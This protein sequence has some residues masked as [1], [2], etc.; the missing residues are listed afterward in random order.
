MT[1]A[2]KFKVTM[3]YIRLA[4]I[5]IIA[6]VL[7]L[8]QKGIIQN[9]FTTNSAHITSISEAPPYE[10]K[11]Q[12]I[13][14][15]NKPFFTQDDIVRGKKEVWEE[16]S[17]LDKS[18]RVGSAFANVCTQT[19]PTEK[20]GP[21]GQIKPTGWKQAKYPGIIDSSPPYLYNRAHSIAFCLT[22][23]NANKRNLF[24]GT[25]YLNQELM[26]P[27]EMK[28]LD[29]LKKYP[30][31]HVLYRVTPHFSGK[32]LLAR[33]VLIEAQSIEKK[34]LVFC[35][36]LYNIQPGITIDYATGSSKATKN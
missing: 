23:E 17:E 14:N 4:I 21:I 5:A 29:Y 7:F 13:I 32:E 30:D 19:M 28:V 2:T 9:P 31:R 36:Y 25:R 18:G 16:Y 20:R 3:N 8:W 15:K 24:T 22:G 35:V 27:Y 26:L 6:V 33:G 10:G 1:N 34:D 11:D 12:V